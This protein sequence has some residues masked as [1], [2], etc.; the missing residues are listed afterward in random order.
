VA[1]LTPCTQYAI[2]TGEAQ[3]GF[4]SADAKHLRPPNGIHASGF[5]RHKQSAA[6]AAGAAA[7][8]TAK[9]KRNGKIN[10]R[11][12][13]GPSSSS[14]SS[15]RQHGKKRASRRRSQE[16]PLFESRHYYHHHRS[17]RGL[18]S[19]DPAAAAAAVMK[20]VKVPKASLAGA[21]MVVNASFGVFLL[22]GTFDQ[23]G[24]QPLSS[25]AQRMNG[26]YYSVASLG[27]QQQRQTQQRQQLLLSQEGNTVEVEQRQQ[28]KNMKSLGIPRREA[29][30]SDFHRNRK[31][32]ACYLFMHPYRYNAPM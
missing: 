4:A 20:K 6:E 10:S 25:I 15:S 13:A 22:H 30:L 31:D 29:L 18:L 1:L 5:T 32:L 9:R 14:S 17:R 8:R 3:G 11:L 23:C 12:L 16:T 27:S 26:S 7:A 19:I 28:L 24:W 21:E 2:T